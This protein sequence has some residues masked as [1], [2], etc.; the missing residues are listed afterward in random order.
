VRGDDL[1]GAQQPVAQIADANGL[2]EHLVGLAAQ[3]LPQLDH[4]RGAGLD[5]LTAVLDA[6]GDLAQAGPAID[7]V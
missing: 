1:A 4:L 7:Q 3:P 6:M 2:G 5:A